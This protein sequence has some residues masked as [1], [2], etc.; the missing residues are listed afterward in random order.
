M[1]ISAYVG[2][3]GSGKSYEVVNSVIIPACMAGR[4]IVTNIYGVSPEK[5]YDYCVNKKKAARDSLGD[6]AL[7]TNEQVKD[8]LFFPY[9]TETG[10]SPD[11]LCKP[12]DLICLDESWRIWENDKDIHAN[13]RSFIAEHRH[14]A[15]EL[16]GVTCDLVLMNQ[17]VANLPRFIKDRVE[18]TYR[19]SKLKALGFNKRYRVDI[20]SGIKLFKA[21]QTA[22][23]LYKYDKDIFPLYSSYENGKGKE[24]TVDSRQNVFRSAKLWVIVVGLIVG[25]IASIIFLISFFSTAG[26]DKTVSNKE[27]VTES[28]VKAAPLNTVEEVKAAPKPSSEWRIAGRLK[29][30]GE[31]LVILAKSDGRLRVVPASQFIFDGLMMT[32]EVDGETVTVYSG[33]IK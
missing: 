19:M 3:P 22:Y 10:I 21:N 5:I 26:L 9:K 11:S 16:T 24:V 32:G 27:V 23:K 18:T 1:A 2:I 20:F 14:F 13:H 15:D 30:N 4:R 28:A 29:Q 33:A 8:A 12:G 31:S 7:V 25:G 6:I 17:A